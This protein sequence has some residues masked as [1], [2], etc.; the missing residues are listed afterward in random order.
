MVRTKSPQAKASGFFVWC[1]RERHFSRM[2]SATRPI[3]ACLHLSPCWLTIPVAGW[4]S[5]V[6]RRAHNPKVTGSNPVPATNIEARYA[7]A[8]GLFAYLDRI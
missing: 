4:S 6:A 8:S 7:N 2:S 5:S 1:G 3:E